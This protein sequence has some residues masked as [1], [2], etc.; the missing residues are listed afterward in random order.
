MQRLVEC[1]RKPATTADGRM[2]RRQTRQTVCA[3][4]R[5]QASRQ[6][7]ATGQA[8]GREE[9]SALEEVRTS[10]AG[11]GRRMVERLAADYPI[12]WRA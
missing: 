8:A 5:R 6:S 10:R 4:K 7:R 9:L 3:A 12:T 1:E 11:R 2:N